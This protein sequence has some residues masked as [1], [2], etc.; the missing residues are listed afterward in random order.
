MSS[1]NT[2]T[3]VRILDKEYCIACPADERDALHRASTYVNDKMREVSDNGRLIGL[4]R[5]AVMAA[6]NITHELLQCKQNDGDADFT[7]FSTRIKRLQEKVE[8]ALNSGQ[9]LDLQ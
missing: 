9:Q 1:Q 6:L 4:D 2:P 8:L 5:I 3:T 7:Q